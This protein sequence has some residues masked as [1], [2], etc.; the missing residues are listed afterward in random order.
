MLKIKGQFMVY[1]KRM[2]TRVLLASL[3]MVEEAL[4][5]C[6]YCIAIVHVYRCILKSTCTCTP[7]EKY[8][9]WHINIAISVWWPS[10]HTRVHVYR[11]CVHCSTRVL[12]Q[13]TRLECT[14]ARI[15]GG[16]LARTDSPDKILVIFRS[17]I[18]CY[19][20]VLSNL[21]YLNYLNYLTN[22]TRFVN[23]AYFR[24]IFRHENN[25]KSVFQII[26]WLFLC[27]NFKIWPLNLTNAD[28]S[29]RFN[30]GGGW[31]TNGVRMSSLVWIGVNMGW[32]WA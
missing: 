29:D 13:W 11:Y 24:M 2:Y 28:V 30:V 10:C 20:Y 9:I 8:S 14:N 6:Y 12:P 32:E 21:N 18:F 4:E 5:Y 3:T 27:N 7:V 31:W 15:I 19:R 26:T 22:W 1:W 17:F 16:E 23:P 25:T